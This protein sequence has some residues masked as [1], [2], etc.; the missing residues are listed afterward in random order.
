MSSSPRYIWITGGIEVFSKPE[1][2]FNFAPFVVESHLVMKPSLALISRLFLF[3]L[4]A[5]FAAAQ[6]PPNL[7]DAATPRVSF[8]LDWPAQNPPRYSITLDSNGHL[9]YR[10]EPTA[11]PNGGTAPTPFVVQWTATD[12]TRNKVFDSVRKLNYFQGNFESKAKVAHTGQKTLAYQD[13]SHHTSTR[14]N[15]SDNPL[16]RDLAQTFQSIA[17]T[18]EMGR[19]LT[20]DARFDKLGIDADLKALQEQQHEGNAIEFG[21]IQPVLQHIA[22]DPAFMR[23]SQQRAKDILRAAGLSA[24]TPTEAE[25]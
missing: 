10:S 23:M 17:T 18:A 14:F 4:F 16:V 5:T 8:S 1:N 7:A 6:N 25:K 22:E 13:A 12:N 24:T 15:Y 3:A 9:T 21:S 11:D 19:K 20:Y 2:F